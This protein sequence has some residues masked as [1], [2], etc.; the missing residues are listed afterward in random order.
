MRLKW[1]V[2]LAV[3]VVLV[4]LAVPLA[5]GA[6]GLFPEERDDPALRAIG[7]RQPGPERSWWPQPR[8]QGSTWHVPKVDLLASLEVAFDR[9][10]LKVAEGLALWE[11]LREELQNFRRKQNARTS[12]VSFEHWR[13]SDHD[14]L[15]LA[16]AMAC[17]GAT[18]RRGQ[19]ALRL[20]R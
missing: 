4:A 8:H 6:E 9:G 10:A 5:V 20:I 14:D 12:H 13:E 1:W 7:P 19:Q 2:A 16:V 18:A 3:S 11:V 15:V 17:W